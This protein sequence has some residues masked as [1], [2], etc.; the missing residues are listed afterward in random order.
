MGQ[1]CRAQWRAEHLFWGTF[2]DGDTVGYAAPALLD[3]LTPV[4]GPEQTARNDGP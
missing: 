3:T 2:F 4:E 1:R